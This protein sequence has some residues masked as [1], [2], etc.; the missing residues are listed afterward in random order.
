MLVLDESSLHKI[1]LSNGEVVLV[2]DGVGRPL[3][4]DMA[5][6]RDT[7][8][9]NIHIGS[10]GLIDESV[11]ASGRN[12][13]I[14]LRLNDQGLRCLVR[15][16]GHRGDSF[17]VGWECLGGTADVRRDEVMRTKT[18]SWIA[19]VI[20]AL[21]IDDGVLDYDSPG[22]GTC[23]P[24]PDRARPIAAEYARLIARLPPAESP[25][26]TRRS[27]FPPKRAAF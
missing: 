10:V 18:G 12:E 5:S 27:G 20:R 17:H 6:E 13:S 16:V 11:D 7:Y 21:W 25:A 23:P 9:R 22:V 14:I 2:A 8:E 4:V 24:H 1:V 15:Q 26:T 19:I 3:V